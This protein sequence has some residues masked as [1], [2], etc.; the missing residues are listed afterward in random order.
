MTFDAH[1]VIIQNGRLQIGTEDQPFQHKL[2]VTIWGSKESPY[3]PTFGNK[4]IALMEGVL[5]IHG[6]PRTP[7]WTVLQST[8]NAG[9]S[10][11]TLNVPID[12]QVGEHIIIASSDVDQYQSEE[13]TIT[14]VS[15]QTVT[16]NKPLNFQHYAAVETYGTRQVQIR[17][18]V[19]LLTRNVVIQGDPSSNATQYG[20]QIMVHSQGDDATRSAKLSYAE[21]RLA[22]QAFQLGRYPIHFHMA[23]IVDQ[24]YV[25]GNSIHNTFNRAV[26]I[27]GVSYLTFEDNVCYRVMGHTVFI[28]DGVETHNL[29]QNNLVINTMASWSLLNTDQTPASFWITN[30]NN[31]Y[32]GNHAA[33]SDRYGFW[34]SLDEFPIG[35]SATTTVCPRGT[36]LGL[37]TDNVAHSSGK[38]GLRIFEEFIPRTYP[39]AP[40][41][42]SWAADPYAANPPVQ[43]TISNFLTYKNNHV[44]LI[45]ERMGAIQFVNI[46]AIDN[47]LAG[48]EISVSDNSPEGM[49]LIN[50]ALAVGLSQNPYN[51]QRFQDGASKGV[52]TPKTENFLVTNVD[53]Y[54]Y[55]GN[56]VAIGTCSHC[57]HAAATDSGARTVHFQGLSFHNVTQRVWFN[58]PQRCILRDDDGTL[59]GLSGGGTV[60]YDY[61][62]LEVPECQINQAVY[63]GIVCNNSVEVR[64]IAFYN[65]LPDVD[66]RMMPIKIIR[67]DAGVSVHDTDANKY[68]LLAMREKK[69]PEFGWAVP[70]ITNYNYAVHWN[71]GQDWT[72]M[73]VESSVRWVSTDK[74]VVLVHNHSAYREAY[75]VLYTDRTHNVT[76]ISNQT[77]LFTTAAPTTRLLSSVLL[78]DWY[79]DVNNSLL[80]LNIQGDKQ[81]P[82]D[83]TGFGCKLNCPKTIGTTPKEDRVRRWSVPTDWPSGKVPVDGENVV[84]NPE[85]IMLLDEDTKSLGGLEI[86]GDLIFDDLKNIPISLTSQKIWVRGQL[87]A[88]NTE[89][90]YK[91]QITITL[92]GG[93]DDPYYVLAQKLPVSNKVIAVTG[94]LSLYGSFQGNSWSK[95]TSYVS[96]FSDT[97]N[98]DKILGWKVNDTIVLAPS[99]QVWSEY[100]TAKIKTIT[101]TTIT[102]WTPLK[103][104]HYGTTTTLKSDYGDSL[105]LSAEVGLLSRNILIQGTGQGGWGGWIIVTQI[106]DATGLERGNAL[107]YGVELNN[108]G[109]FDTDQ[110]G[111]SFVQLSKAATNSIVKYSSIHNSDGWNAH[112]QDAWGVVFDNNVFYQSSRCG[113]MIEGK[114]S[115]SITFTN[116]LVV[117][118]QKRFIAAVDPHMV[119]FTAAIQFWSDLIADILVTGNH[120]AGCE[121]HGIAAKGGDCKT[122][123]GFY[124]NVVH[125]ADV[126]YLAKDNGNCL[127]ISRIGIHK[128]NLGIA[129]IFA[130]NTIQASH[131]M[132]TDCTKGITLNTGTDGY[133]VKTISVKSSYFAGTSFTDCGSAKNCYTSATCSNLLG[134][135]VS[136]NH[137]SPKTI[138]PSASSLPWDHIKAWGSFRG[139]M[140]LDQITLSNFKANDGCKSVYAIRSNNDLSD[141]SPYVTVSN[142]KLVNTDI[143]SIAYIDDPDQG[144]I[145]VDDCGNWPCTGIRNLLI[146][147]TDSTLLGKPGVI[148]PNNPL[149]T[150]TKSC[151]LST[152]GNSYQC[153][154]LHWGQVVFESQDVDKTARIFSPINLTASDSFR[155]DL[156]TMMDHTWNGFYTGLVRLSRFSGIIQTNKHYTFLYKGTL[157]V[158]QYFQ[159]QGAEKG[160]FI[161]VDFTYTTSQS[162]RVEL[163]DGTVVKPTIIKPDQNDNLLEDTS[164]CGSNVYTLISNKIQ[165]TLTS[166]DKCSVYVRVTNSVM[167]TARYSTTVEDFY[168]NDGTTKFIDRVAAILNIPISSIRV[169]SIKSGSTILDFFVDS[170]FQNNSDSTQYANADSELQWFEA[171]LNQASSNGSLDIDSIPNGK[172]IGFNTTRSMANETTTTTQASSGSSSIPTLPIILGVTISV[173]AILI[174]LVVIF[175]WKKHKLHLK[176][177]VQ[178]EEHAKAKGDSYIVSGSNSSQ[179]ANQHGEG[180][181]RVNDISTSGIHHTVKTEGED[182]GTKLVLLPTPAFDVS[183]D[184]GPSFFK[185]KMIRKLDGKKKNGSMT[186]YS[187][188]RL[189]SPSKTSTMRDHSDQVEDLENNQ[190]NFETI[191]A[192]KLQPDA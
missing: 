159:L 28:E 44:G 56:M 27:H 138:P 88:G 131:L 139:V 113:I 189:E 186:D 103:Y 187:S 119:D 125:S 158:V 47:I 166:D 20:V 141:K 52:I 149:L 78:G 165:F 84:I 64:R 133:D 167:A 86:Q 170:Q 32:K 136:Y 18:E 8:A 26:T 22:G 191:S 93:K 151:K 129:T 62:H 171:M 68:T 94:N 152:N 40:A 112:V 17:A 132:V 77:T 67:L 36:Q 178:D 57:E 91:N 19:G 11:I 72:G 69:L 96:A 130:T 101:G 183:D 9:D 2:T 50:G 81:G 140:T 90:P 190:A 61:P 37:F 111:L 148:I 66:M 15:G 104:S 176:N 116:N 73:R 34:I 115:S 10:T 146:K 82:L 108:M 3:L 38:Y 172:V 6:T 58:I 42:Q 128:C 181:A 63:N 122:K 147:A 75:E 51:T 53:F 175:T 118:N 29:I 150:K 163:D 35:P 99:G 124:D 14:A 45:G 179:V 100:E 188:L 156:N 76:N 184:V 127:D 157:P 59:T 98:V 161:H 85:W 48:I 25:N 121:N 106:S 123:Y 54:N 177:K 5:D 13:R 39:C 65:A 160:D 120:V 89:T 92:T 153:D 43:A 70:F 182:Y 4:V 137:V 97:I 134:V 144:N 7:T 180:Y 74:P 142:V 24:S 162:I 107:L 145:G 71:N 80:Y 173:L 83:I 102:L 79:H 21:V 12:W 154:D 95:L 41:A 164:S 55:N 155:N 169:V 31:M 126:G 117:G 46:T 16:L 33:G 114:A 174:L 168:S 30:P 110:A 143:D 1:Y 185:G 135:E 109:Q 87:L 60:T 49:H 192:I 23:G 105:D